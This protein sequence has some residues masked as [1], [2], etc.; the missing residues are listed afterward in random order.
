MKK[1]FVILLTFVVG[2]LQ[3]PAA[4]PE[5]A[6][7]WV[8]PED[9]EVLHELRVPIAQATVLVDLSASNTFRKEMF[10]E[11]E[12]LVA[13]VPDQAEVCVL[14]ISE[15]SRASASPPWCRGVVDAF[16]C[17]HQ[18]IKL[19][20]WANSTKEKPAYLDAEQRIKREMAACEVDHKTDVARRQAT[21]KAGL[22]AW[23]AAARTTQWTDLQGAIMRTQQSSK[24]S[25]GA[26]WIFSDME[27]DPDPQYRRADNLTID[28]EGWAVHV[29]Q[30]RKSGA[31]YDTTWQTWWEGLFAGWGDPTV[32]WID[33][34]QGEFS[35][36]T[37]LEPK[38][39]SSPKTNPASS[40]LP[41]PTTSAGGVAFPDDPGS[42][43]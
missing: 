28:L 37:L 12:A 14:Q 4:Q 23:I 13:T 39:E 30:I 7:A 21:A 6:Q 9:L 26:L 38:G 43:Q 27:D 36:A 8:L 11:V 33:F 41:V 1:V 24:V 18:P 40:A 20:G 35:K 5:G 15:D 31:G 19:F 3:P 42:I 29:R 32:D 10:A 16:D 2:C 22:K 25:P 34:S 17:T